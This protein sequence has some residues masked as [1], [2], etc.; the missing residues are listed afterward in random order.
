MSKGDANCDVRKHDDPTSAAEPPRYLNKLLQ[1]CI[2]PTPNTCLLGSD[3]L[4]VIVA[5]VE[6][7]FACLDED[8]A[9]TF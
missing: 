9:G 6:L 1:S 7:V 4:E 5:H 8:E 3:N 2:T